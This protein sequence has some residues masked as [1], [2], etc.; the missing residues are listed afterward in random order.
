MVLTA[1]ARISAPPVQRPAG[2]LLAAATITDVPDDSRV[3]F[4]VEFTSYL[5]GTGGL[6]P[7]PCG[8]VTGPVFDATKTLEG[9]TNG[10]GYPFAVYAG[11][12]CDLFGRDE[13][14]QAARDKLTGLEEALVS[15]A[16]LAIV[17][18]NLTPVVVPH[19]HLPGTDITE[20]LVFDV[21]ILE[22]WAAANY[23]GTPLLHIDR[24]TA[25]LLIA[26]GYIT[27]TI[28]GG[29]ITGQGTPVANGA[30][31]PTQTLF[32][33]GAVHMWRTPMQVHSADAHLL[34][35]SQGLAERVYTVATDC[36]MAELEH[37]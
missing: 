26:A 8:T 31:Y 2:G 28:D 6:F 10:T 29:L 25:A 17:Q 19:S 11:V 12:D 9:G 34:N 20:P 22:A 36:F 15:T 30:G 5:C 1:P 24:A 32:I 18:A 3:A 13:Y 21:G 27:P 35:T 14:A 23:G 37:L 4:G 7:A 16:Y 33:T